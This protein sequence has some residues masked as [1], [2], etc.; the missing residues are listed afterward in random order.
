MAN[1]GTN[2]TAL[3][4]EQSPTKFQSVK[5]SKLLTSILVILVI[6]CV[7]V[8]AILAFIIHDKVNNSSST[9]MYASKICG[10]IESN[11]L[12]SAITSKW[13]ILTGELWK[14]EGA[15]Y[16]QWFD[17]MNE[18]I[19]DDFHWISTQYTNNDS[20][21]SEGGWNSK[22]EF[23]VTGNPEIG[24]PTYAQGAMNQ[25]LIR[26][27]TATNEYIEC[28]END[29]SL[30]KSISYLFVNL[31]NKTSLESSVIFNRM[32]IE[33]MYDLKSNKWL[34]KSIHAQ[35]WQQ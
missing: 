30:A 15:N 17:F 22:Q 18:S 2:M 25:G 11:V 8:I 26:R 13:L 4:T 7:V 9:T 27:P 1:S 12:M 29:T 16:E 5:Q 19:S 10:T 14:T 6:I 20:I 24:W 21:L 32:D 28:V 31:I 34:R 3:L 33:W 35:I 23:L